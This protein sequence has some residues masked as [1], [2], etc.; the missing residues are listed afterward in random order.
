MESLS[1]VRL[2]RMLWKG[3]DEDVGENNPQEHRAA[4]GAHQDDRGGQGQS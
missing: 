2:A 4:E 1:R 3:A